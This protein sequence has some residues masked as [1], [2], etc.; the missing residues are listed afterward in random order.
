MLYA[1]A[2]M[3]IP[4]GFLS[5]GVSLFCW[6]VTIATLAVAVRR[7]DGQ[8]GQRGKARGRAISVGSDQLTIGTS[9]GPITVLVDE[10]TVIRVP[11]VE[12]PTL[13]DIHSGDLVE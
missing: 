11:G 4:D 9:Q 12:N 5:L 10:E 7:Q 2:P 13:A 1:P 6:V 3:H 8:P